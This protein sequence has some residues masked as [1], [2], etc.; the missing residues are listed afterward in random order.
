MG[1]VFTL[2]EARD[3][4]PE[5]RAVTAPVHAL[6]E[7]LALELREAE[8]A[9]DAAR[10]ESLQERLQDLVQSWSEAMRDLGAD[11]KGLWLVDFD[12]GDGYWCWAW[13]EAELDH[14]HSYEAGFQG[15]RPAAERPVHAPQP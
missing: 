15:R 6:A 13:P 3:R 5:V 12:S 11:V 4:M 10:I 14:W 7:S 8:E 2:E 1:R 9:R